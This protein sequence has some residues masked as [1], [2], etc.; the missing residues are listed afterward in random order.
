MAPK[1]LSQAGLKLHLARRG[2]PWDF[3][4][5]L[6]TGEV[7]P[8]GIDLTYDTAHGLG[9]VTDDP[10]CRRRRGVARQVHDRHVTGGP[11]VRR[12]ADLP[13]VRV[14]APLLPGEARHHDRDLKELE[15]K[16]VGMDGW[17][18]SG[19]TWTRV[20][21]RQAGVDIWKIDWVIAPVDGPRRC[22]ARPRRAG[23]AAQRD[24]RAGRQVTG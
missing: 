21:L 3:I 15:G 17:P 6:L 12:P 7:V 18:N 8:E 13:D 5:P 14:Q 11:I 23:L 20:T 22:R 1:E 24:G 16:R 10:A 2:Y 4:T 19:N 9:P